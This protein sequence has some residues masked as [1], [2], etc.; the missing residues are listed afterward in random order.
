MARPE[1]RTDR[2]IVLVEARKRAAGRRRAPVDNTLNDRLRPVGWDRQ[3]RYQSH[4]LRGRS[5]VE[6]YLGRFG[7][8]FD[9][10]RPTGKLEVHDRH[11][12][13]KI[14]WGAVGIAVFRTPQDPQK[15]AVDAA[16]GD[17]VSADAI[18]SG[19]GALGL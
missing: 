2:K 13:L 9:I 5:G 19:R 14:A 4:Q 18:H 3:G 15:A 12:R 1:S 6:V 8:H 16:G 7:N 11:G 10:G 17:V